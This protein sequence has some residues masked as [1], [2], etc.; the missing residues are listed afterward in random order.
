[1]SPERILELS[2]Q[3]GILNVVLILTLFFLASLVLYILKQSREREVEQAKQNDIRDNRWCI[4]VE[5]IEERTAERH[6]ANQSAM[7]KL[8]EADRR[9][10]EEHEEI[11]RNQKAGQDQH[12]A[13]ANLLN[14]LIIK[15]KCGA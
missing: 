1:M 14:Q 12:Q 3:Y 9:Q 10:R 13:I 11:L 4:L 15:V 8:E 6:L 5:K 7:A 2:S